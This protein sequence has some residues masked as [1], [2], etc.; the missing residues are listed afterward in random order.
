MYVISRCLL[1][2]NCKYNGGNNLR[3]DVVEFIKG[4]EYI[5]ICP[6]CTGGLTSPREPAE[7][8]ACQSGIKVIDR[9]GRDVTKEFVTGAELSMQA[10]HNCEAEGKVIEGAILKANSPSCGCGL[11]YDGSF[12]GKL[13]PGNGVFAQMLEEHGV[14]VATEKNFNEILIGKDRYN[15]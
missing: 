11:I 8:F 9:A 5:T 6:E 15:D 3:E 7:L 4:Q 12:S 1:G 10:V 14:K 13:I 2:V